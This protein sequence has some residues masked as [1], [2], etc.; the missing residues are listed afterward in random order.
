MTPTPAVSSDLDH[1]PIDMMRNTGHHGARRIAEALARPVLAHE[2]EIAADAA[3]GDDDGA[4]MEL[5]IADEAAAGLLAA[6][7]GGGLEQRARDARDTAV[8]ADEA[9]R[10]MAELQRDA[11]LADMFAHAAHEGFEH[12]RPGAPGDMEARHGIAVAMRHG[13][14][15]ARPSRRRE[16]SACP[17]DAARSAS[18]RRKNRHRP[19]P[20]CA[21][22][23]PPAG[24]TAPSPSSPAA[25]AR[26][27]HG[28]A[29]AAARGC[30]RRTDRR[31]TRR[32]ARRASSRP[33]G[34]APAPSCRHPPVRQQPPVR[35]VLRQQRSHRRFSASSL[36]PG[37]T[38]QS[39]GTVFAQ[40]C[41]KA[42][43]RDQ[44]H[45]S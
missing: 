35:Q 36:H 4:G 34:R 42:A 41:P 8:G 26:G 17:A 25:R 43:G 33:P 45:R 44:C 1:A 7:D 11:P 21:A 23:S 6:L 30:R 29:C 15:R 40:P 27:C 20:P 37:K 31:A 18:R 2:V 38:R 22:S 24:R 3:R 28:C 32:P 10:L 16:T 9:R 39:Q 5:E 14:R 19:A 12:A 13:R